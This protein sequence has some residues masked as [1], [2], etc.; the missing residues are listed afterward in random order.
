MKIVRWLAAGTALFSIFAA[1]YTPSSNPVIDG[2]GLI[3]T[4]LYYPMIIA[5]VIFFII[6]ACRMFDPS[7]RGAA[8][9]VC[10]LS[11]S[12]PVVALFGKY[13]FVTARNDDKS[14]DTEDYEQV[15]ADRLLDYYMKS[16]SSFHY[17]GTDEEVEASG[18][19][20][21]LRKLGNAANP[22][23]WEFEIK[24]QGNSV[25]DLWG[26]P[27]RF[28]LDR[29]HDGY[30]D[31]KRLHISVDGNAVPNLNYRAAVAVV[32]SHKDGGSYEETIASK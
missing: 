28:G 6:G 21:Y 23:P 8:M 5:S 29:N 26:K 11:L 2:P 30:I 27:L 17:I 7:M 1:T 15:V 4:F 3:L 10:L 31:M 19:A 25:L 18:F 13:G 12:M 24:T 20:D 32:L 22:Y 14:D 9:L 16:P